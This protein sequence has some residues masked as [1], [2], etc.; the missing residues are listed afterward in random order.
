MT[1]KVGTIGHVDQRPLCAV[2]GLLHGGRAMCGSV[3]NAKKC[4]FN[5]ECEHQ[6]EA[7]QLIE[8]AEAAEAKRLR[9]AERNR[10]QGG[11]A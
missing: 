8:I 3:I 5:G 1:V 7:V 9:R 6:R 2:R 11:A 4:G 10:K